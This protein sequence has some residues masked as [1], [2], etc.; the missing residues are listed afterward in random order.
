[1]NRC[2]SRARL[3]FQSMSARNALP[4]VFSPNRQRQFPA[5][6]CSTTASSIANW[7]AIFDIVLLNSEDLADHLL[8]AGNLR[9]APGALRRASILAVPAEDDQAHSRAF[10]F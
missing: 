9:E 4:R 3:V 8:P 10:S 1:M 5:S 6:T 7:P 2:R